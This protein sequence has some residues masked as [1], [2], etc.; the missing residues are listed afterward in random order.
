MRAYRIATF[1]SLTAVLIASANLVGNTAPQ[2]PAEPPVKGEVEIDE[3]DRIRERIRLYLSRHGEGG[4][5]DPERRLRAIRDDYQR[6]RSE[7]ATRGISTQAIG[8]TNWI[9]LGPTNGAGRTVSIAPHPTDPATIYIGAAGGG[10]WKTTDSGTSWR[11]LTDSLTD[12]SVGAV[13]FAPS[14]PNIVYLGTGEG[15]VAIDFIPGIGFLKSTDGGENWIL[16][17]SVVAEKFYRILVHP[18]SPLEVIA[19]TSQ[20]GLRST[21]GGATWTTVIDPNVFGHVTDIVRHPTNPLIL[22][23]TTWDVFGWCVRRGCGIQSSR[24]L[25]STDGGVTWRKRSRGLPVSDST[26]RV[27]RLSIAISPSNPSVLYVATSILETA[28]GQDLSHIYK[29]TNEGASWSELTSLST[30]SSFLVRSYLGGQAWYDNTIIVSPTN[31]NVVIA[32]G[33]RYVRSTDGGTTWSTPP[34]EGSRVHVDAHDLRYQGSR[35][36]I[37]NDGGVWSTDDDGETSTE[38]NTGLVT[39]QYYAMANDPANRNRICA[40]S[41]DNGTDWRPDAG[42]TLWTNVLGGDGFDCAFSP[43]VPSIAFG[44]IQGASIFRTKNAEGE[45]PRFV[46]AAIRTRRAEALLQCADRRSER[47]GHDLHGHESCLADHNRSGHMDA[48][49]HNDYDWVGLEYVDRGLDSRGSNKQLDTNGGE[50]GRHLPLNK[51]R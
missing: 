36:Y 11:P 51:R 9:S 28:L 26:D 39:R 37:A 44:T 27:N 3:G 18:T 4:R 49:A 25:Q 50:G 21:D 32:G 7:D 6:R 8:G 47:A 24:V 38:H 35:L 45:L 10:V 43:G 14:D 20:G 41:Q 29:S 33:V 16:P 22:Y 48:N 1:I 15:S 23:A 42:G 12:L 30:H 40:G 2:Q 19:G 17:S 5:L 13:T 46:S 31:E 34:F